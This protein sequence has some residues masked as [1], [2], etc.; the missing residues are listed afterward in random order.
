MEAP[1]MPMTNPN[2]L[3]VT[4]DSLRK[5][6]VTPD[7][8]PYLSEV[9]E[10]GI[11]FD[12]M[13]STA[14]ATAASFTALIAS[15]YYSDVEG[16]GL[17]DEEFTTLG[18]AF[19]DA[20]Y[21][22]VGRSTN[23]FTSSYY[24]YD[25][26]FDVF[27]SPT[28]GLKFTIRRYLDEDSPLF[29]FL[30]WGYHHWLEFNAGQGEHQLS[31]WNT[32]AEDVNDYAREQVD[33][34]DE[35]WF[36]WLHHMDPHHPLELPE[37]YLPESV[38]D[39]GEGQALT[40]ELPGRVPAGRSDDLE[41]VIELYEA[42]CRHWDDEFRSLHQSLDD[43]TLV[44]VVGDHGE[45]LGEHDRYGHPHEMW[46]ELT[47]VPCVIYHPDL[48][49][50]TIGSLQSTIDLPPTLLDLAGIDTPFSMRGSPIDITNPAPREHAVGTIETPDNVG[51]VRT[52]DWTWMRHES[53]RSSQDN[54]GELVY[55]ASEEDV[56]AGGMQNANRR[57]DICQQLA[58][59]F[60]DTVDSEPAAAGH[61]MENEQVKQHMADLG[62]LQQQ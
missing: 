10:D 57:E 52:Q 7:V 4:V 55:P 26:G 45:L 13:Y 44:V 23:K 25:R 46:R 1:P 2:I 58:G 50:A 51:M 6:R 5:D 18:E 40:R 22:T 31:W 49:S 29:K 11:W 62:Y 47:N 28:S 34:L 59:V 33:G 48:P 43:D 37:D 24:N 3:Y 32:P 14:P 9:K 19:D 53:R 39:R 15:R 16:I 61:T 12:E 56:A 20:G 38:A 30:E 54:Q 36:T 17:P 8:M 41:T 35:P 60:E 21:Q 27:D 42:E